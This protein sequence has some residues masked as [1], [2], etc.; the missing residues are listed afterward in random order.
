MS[1]SGID[2]ALPPD[3]EGCHTQ[4][5]VYYRSYDAFPASVCAWTEHILCYKKWVLLSCQVENVD[6]IAAFAT[7]ALS[8]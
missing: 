2:N 7:A 4:R 1:I 5:F 6:A 8:G 3:G